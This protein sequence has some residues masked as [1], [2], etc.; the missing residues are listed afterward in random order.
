MQPPLASLKKGG[1]GVG[2]VSFSVSM[3]LPH[4]PI[5]VYAPPGQY[6]TRV[7]SARCSTPLAYAPPGTVHHWRMPHQVQYT[8]RICSTRCNTPHAYA[9]PG[10]VH[11]MRVLHQMQY[12]TCVCSTRC[13]TPHAYA[14][15]GAVH[16]MRMLHQMQYTTCVCSTRCSTPHA[17]A[18][19]DAVHHTRMLHQVQYTTCVCSTRCSTPHACAPPDAVHHMRVLHQVQY[20]TGVCSTR[21]S[22]PHT[23]LIGYTQ[24]VLND[25]SEYL[26]TQVLTCI[27]S[28][29][30]YT[31]V[32]AWVCA[33]IWR[34][35][36]SVQQ[37]LASLC[38]G[39]C[40]RHTSQSREN[41]VTA[42]HS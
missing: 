34:Y 7:C 4:S 3:D 19:P 10:A 36:R 9:P 29:E 38:G 33:L 15:P 28:L 31:Y 40:L 2:I 1:G 18:P 37:P 11:H 21:C 12:T 22:T 13:S 5:H 39:G 16:H 35:S 26:C 30:R 20:T 17:C 27:G 41:V 23:Y 25:K 6:T 8:T 24:E 32:R 42:C 14:P